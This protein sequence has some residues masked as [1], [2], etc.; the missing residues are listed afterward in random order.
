MSM[1]EIQ[2]LTALLT[3]LGTAAWAVGQIRRA[4]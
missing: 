2:R 1:T 4:L 3:L